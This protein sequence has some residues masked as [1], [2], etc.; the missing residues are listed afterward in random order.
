MGRYG[1]GL[2]ES[3][4]IRRSNIPRAGDRRTCRTGDRVEQ[5]RLVRGQHD[6][7]ADSATVP[8][9]VNPPYPRSSIATWGPLYVGTFLIFANCHQM[10]DVP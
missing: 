9:H 10:A 2:P 5:L 3:R 7:D 1:V 4:P 6:D 8:F